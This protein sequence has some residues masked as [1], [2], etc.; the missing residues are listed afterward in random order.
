[1]RI[2]RDSIGEVAVPDEALWGGSTQRAVE[3]FA[4][5]GYRV[6]RRLIRALGLIKAAAAE[7]NGNLAR[8]ELQRADLI[9][10]AAREVAKGD[11]DEHFVIDVFQ[12]GS[13]TSTHTNANEVIANRC[14]QLA[15]RPLGSRDPIHPNDHVN[16]GQ[17]SNDVFPSAIHLAVAEG[18]ER[19]LDP[20]LERL[21]AAL[22]RRS[23]EFDA[24]VKAGR[25]H[26]MDAMPIRMGQ[27]FSGYA[28]QVELARVRTA[29]GVAA[30]S[31]LAIGGTAVGTAVNGHPAFAGLVIERLRGETGIRF[32]E[33]ANHVEAQAARDGLV[34]A[35]GQLKTIAIGLFKIANDLRWMSSGP[36]CGLGELRLPALQPGSSMMP[37][38][39]N[40]VLCEMLMQVSCQVVASDT[41]VTWSG[42]N[43]NFELNTMMPLA[44]WHLLESIRILSSATAIFSERCVEG[45]TVDRERCFQFAEQSLALVTVLAPRIGYDRA[46]ALARECAESGRAVRVV[47]REQGILPDQELDRLL[48]LMAMTSV[49]P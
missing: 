8:L 23:R 1:V 43:G 16:L 34:E 9:Q 6:P 5:S 21:Q 44:A 25:T 49:P 38:K 47:C 24:V 7:A 20:A 18:L 12:T 2:E 19:D 29:T 11:Y 45:V 35:S 30:V 13:G 3:N 4:V 10:L 15:G 41:A 37:G 39:V 31:E 17:S 46:A 36:R 28:R 48:D 22:E 27:V 26:L 42:A 32:Q 40:P 14:A 33:A